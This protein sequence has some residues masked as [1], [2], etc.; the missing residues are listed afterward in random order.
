MFNICVK[1]FNEHKITI[2]TNVDIQKSKTK[3]IYFS[4]NK[5]NIEPA[6]IMLNNIPLPWVE[7]WPHLGNDLVRSDAHLNFALKF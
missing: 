2:S 5:S 3:C 7:T 4:H 1:Y 6:K